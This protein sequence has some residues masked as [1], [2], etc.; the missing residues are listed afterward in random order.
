[1]R[2]TTLLTGLLLIASISSCDLRSETAKEEMEKFD[3][4][5]KTPTPQPAAT[6]G[7]VAPG[8]VVEVDTSL[9]GDAITVNGYEKRRLTCAKFNRVAVNGERNEVTITGP[10]SQ[11]MINGDNN[12]VK[13][14]AAAEIVI[15]GEHNKVEYAR[16]A[17]GKRPFVTDNGGDNAIEKVPFGPA[18]KDR[19]G[20]R[21][22]K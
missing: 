5:S 14:D 3:G 11:M 18:I 2:V 6:D 8:D 20:S 16:Y 22:A 15:N 12:T 21:S 4:P 9:R 17:N 19:S 10:C 13:M 1:M 7:P